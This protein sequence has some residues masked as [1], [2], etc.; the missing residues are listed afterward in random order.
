[1]FKTLQEKKKKIAGLVGAYMLQSSV[2]L[3]SSISDAGLGNAA[4]VDWP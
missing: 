1:M 4:E 3:A 2:A